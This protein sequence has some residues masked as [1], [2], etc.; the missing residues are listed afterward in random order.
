MWCMGDRAAKDALFEGF[1]EVAK[2]LA[3]GRRAEIVDVLA[4]GDRSVE[5]IAAEIDQSVANTSASS[6]GA[7]PAPACSPPDATAHA[8]STGWRATGSPS[9]GRPCA[10]LPRP[11]APGLEKLP[12]LTS[13]TAT[14]SRSST[15]AELAAR[16][17]DG[18]VVVSTSGREPSSEPD[19][20]PAPGRSRS[21]SCAG[22]SALPK[23]TR[24]RGL[25]P[26]SLLRVRRRRGPRA[27][28][29]GL[30]GSPPRRR[31][32]GMEASRPAPTESRPG[33][34]EHTT[35]ER[36]HT[37]DRPG[38]DG[39]REQAAQLGLV[40]D[41]AD[42][43]RLAEFWVE[44]LGYTNLGGAGELRHARRRSR[45]ATQAP[46][47][48][49]HRTQGGQE[50]D[51]L[52]HRDAH[53]RRGGQTGSK[54]SVLAESERTPSRST[55]PA[56][57]SWPTPKATSSASATAASPNRTDTW[58]RRGRRR[59][60]SSGSPTA[61]GSAARRS[62]STS[63]A[64]SWALTTGRPATRPGPRPTSSAGSSGS[65][66]GPTG[67][68]RRRVRAGPGC[69]S[70][71]GPDATS[72]APTSR[73]RA[74]RARSR[75]I[76]DGV[77]G[78]ASYVVATG[79]H[80]PLRPGAFDAVVHTDVLCCLGPKLAVLRACQPVLRPGGRLAFTT[81]HVAPGL[82]GPRHRRAVRAGPPHVATRRPYP[83]LVAQAGFIDVIEIDVTDD[84][85]RTQRAWLD[86]NE[87]ACRRVR[88]AV[89][90]DKAFALGQADRRRAKAAIEDG[91]LRRSLI[92]AT[93]P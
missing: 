32:P 77:A 52:R 86:A 70:P 40:L 49:G 3:S 90:S 19:T 74:A 48:A 35:T 13:V 6:A 2:A 15:A 75:S 59:R 7:W 91:L 26:R 10:T 45:R 85:A 61:T 37:R 71:S 42:P 46:A 83:E 11:T 68:H 64:R 66:R 24:G 47:P 41:C 20:S 29:Q 76:E 12:P 51:A 92:T 65:A 23:D 18:A 4:Q 62:G 80:Q 56:G 79:R 89:T 57:W 25:L 81:I 33:D 43:E 21:A 44:A 28:P 84:Y 38:P 30:Q 73:R 87:A 16:L 54:D 50:P 17:R 8:S 9:C 34:V 5:E 60:A 93:S 63:R 55:G 22:T 27:Q 58:S 39:R 69:T 14:A 31:L 82:D 53:R 67:R 1:A 36:S 88:L 78:R 72:S